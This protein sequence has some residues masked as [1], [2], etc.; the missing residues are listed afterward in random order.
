MANGHFTNKNARKV[1]KVVE[2]RRVSRGILVVFI[3]I[4]FVLL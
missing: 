3:V 2:K 4:C 1:I